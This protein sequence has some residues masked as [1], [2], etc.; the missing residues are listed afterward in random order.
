MKLIA[1][2]S[3][4]LVRKGVCWHNRRRIFY[5]TAKINHNIVSGLLGITIFLT[6]NPQE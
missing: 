1:N 2:G 5:L 4:G 3:G 6:Q